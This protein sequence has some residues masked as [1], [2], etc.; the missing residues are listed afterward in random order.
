[1]LLHILK[2]F[3]ADV[4]QT[5]WRRCVTAMQVIMAFTPMRYMHIQRSRPIARCKVWMAFWC[6]RN[7]RKDESGARQGFKWYVATVVPEVALAADVVWT[8]WHQALKSAVEATPH[9]YLVM[10]MRSQ[11]PVTSGKFND[12]LQEVVSPILAEDN[13]I[14]CTSYSLRKVQPTA[15]DLRDADWA[16]RFRIG[17]WNQPGMPKPESVMP[18]RYSG[19][20]DA[21][22]L[23]VEAGRQLMI[24]R[25]LGSGRVAGEKLTGVGVR[26][27]KEVAC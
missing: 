9:S 3:L 24:L 4:K 26:V 1:M 18:M 8:C 12:I 5:S 6:F 27:V 14:R 13:S 22:E 16:E 17:L 2:T 10:D 25:A 7:K 15:M 21:G 20:K 11:L 23:E 19:V